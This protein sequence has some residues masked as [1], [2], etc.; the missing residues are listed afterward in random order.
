MRYTWHTFLDWP[1]HVAI[2]AGVPE[3]EAAH[4]SEH[5]LAGVNT[6]SLS[7]PS[8][9][10]SSFPRELVATSRAWHV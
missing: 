5:V 8:R 4:A 7:S 6:P 9:S 10:R 3:E 1:L 2:A